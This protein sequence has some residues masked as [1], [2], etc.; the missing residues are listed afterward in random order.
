VLL[1]KVEFPGFAGM[2]ANN[3]D[4]R[5]EPAMPGVGEA[6][7]MDWLGI[8]LGMIA[9]ENFLGYARIAL[10]LATVLYVIHAI[11][12]GIG[13][14]FCFPVP[15]RYGMFGHV[16]LLLGLAAFNLLVMLIFKVLPVLGV[17][18]YV[19][20]P[21]VTPEIVLT[22][23][24]MERMVPINI[25]WSG[26]PFW[27]NTGC[28]IFKFLFYLEP[29]LLS[30]FVWSAGI[31]IKDEKIEQLGQGR[32][33]MSLGTFF[34]LVVFHLLSLSG[35]SPV[36][37]NVLRVIYTAWYF[38]LVIYMLQY[39]MMLLKLRA[40]LYDKIHPKFELDEEEE[41]APKKKKK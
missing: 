21:L 36:L 28:L 27:E 23:Y 41:E 2:M 3:L 30:I 40:V 29:T 13:Y 37:V 33:Q 38:F 1:G 7:N 22:E 34:M 39:T 16:L 20:I 4:Q 18:N 24:N 5:R 10:V 31:A 8:Y 17:H 19:M 32:V 6:W 12:W 26:A 25:L 15:R 14:G 11:L 9:G 35:S